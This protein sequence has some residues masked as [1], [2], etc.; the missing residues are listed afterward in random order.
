MKKSIISKITYVIF[1]IMLICGGICLFLI[2]T[3]YDKFV[4]INMPK[5]SDQTVY[6][7]IAFYVCYLIS[8]GILYELMNLFKNIYKDSPFKKE[9]EVILKVVAVLF[10]ILFLII[11]IKSFF[12]PTILTFAVMIIT[13]MVSLS[14][15]VLSQVIKSAIAYKNELDLTV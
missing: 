13:F 9:I 1:L 2:P 6:Y 12:I 8:L 4:G 15:Y 7:Q 11:S 14:F 5:F 10:M 3:L